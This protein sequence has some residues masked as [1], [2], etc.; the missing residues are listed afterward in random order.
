MISGG[1]FC[2]V[3]GSDA[4]AFRAFSYT[5]TRRSP[6]LGGGFIVLLMMPCFPIL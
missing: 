1:K 3:E 4:D 5:Q 2:R 6:L